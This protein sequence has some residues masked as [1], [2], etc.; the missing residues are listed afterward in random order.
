MSATD[1]ALTYGNCYSIHNIQSQREPANACF[2]PQ[3]VTL[4]TNCSV[5]N[6]TL[7]V[8]GSSTNYTME[9]LSTHENCF[10]ILFSIPM[11]EGKI[12]YFGMSVV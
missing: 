2:R 3:N 10:I 11:A 5:R 6:Y 8:V 9:S 1:L 7:T 4:S 12:S